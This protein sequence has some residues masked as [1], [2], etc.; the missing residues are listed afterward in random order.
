MRTV[1]EVLRR[2]QDFLKERGSPS[3]RLD[4]EL[5]LA[6]VLAVERLQ[7]YLLFDKPL[8]EE[9]LGRLREPVR[10][11]GRREPMA[12]VLGTRDF[13]K[14]AFQVGPGVLV[15]RPDT[16]TLV[17]AC[18]PFCE[19]DPVYVADVGAGTGCVGLSLAS[20]RPGVR[21]YAVERSDAARAWLR[22][23]VDALDLST[24]VA[25]LAGDLLDGVPRGRPVDVVVS[26]P[27][28]IPSGEIDALAPEVSAFE[29]RE[30]LDG[31]VDGLEVYRRLVPQAARRA[32]RAVLVEVGAGQA[33]DVCRLFHDA[34]LVHVTT[35]R[36]LS[37]IER[38]VAGQVA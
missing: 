28:Y 11:R 12:Y 34:G 15:P 38:V 37:G 5:I 1:M 31:G 30:A 7:L 2:T 23:N 19:G 26:N 27:P 32:R 33:A 18:L 21:V 36:D 4:A 8:S 3:P 10:R 29:P 14:H 25:V 9:D 16:E 24:R 6:H 35:H 13:W 20:D 22:R 17:E